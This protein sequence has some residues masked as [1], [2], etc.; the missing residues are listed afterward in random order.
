MED[1]EE[2]GLSTQ[3]Q[4]QQELEHFLYH[5]ARCIDE[6]RWEDWLS[7]YLEESIYWVPT[8]R[9]QID[10]LQ[11]ISIVYYDKTSLQ[12]RVQR[13]T[14]P[15]A[16]S[17]ERRPESTHLISNVMLDG[18]FEK[19]CV[20]YHV[21]SSFIALG[22][23]ED[24]RNTQTVYGGKYFHELVR[25]DGKLKIRQKKIVL[26]NCDAPHRNIQILL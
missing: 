15:Q 19:S 4:L 2:N 24:V 17:L 1:R 20:E 23:Q 26:N 8:V 18:V 7:L 6:Q 14:H 25:K 9:D 12:L 3:F 10:P 16:H 22:Y 11:Q 21:S 13:M 5:E